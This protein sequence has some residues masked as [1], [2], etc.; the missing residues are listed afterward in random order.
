MATVL[1]VDLPTANWPCDV[2]IRVILSRG[3]RRSP[4]HSVLF[5]LHGLFGNCENWIELTPLVDKM[6]E[7]DFA[8]IAP[9]AW[10]SWYVDSASQPSESYERFF[11]DDL[12]RWADDTFGPF[13]K[14][15]V[16]GLSMGGYGAF[17]FGLKRPDLF[18]FAYSTSGAFVAP[19]IM[20]AT[21]GFD[22]LK[23]SAVT[24]FG[25]DGSPQRRD[26]DIFHLLRSASSGVRTEFV[27][28]CG[29][30]DS[31]FE[32]NRQLADAFAETNLQFSFQ[33]FPGGHD[34]NYWSDRLTNILEAA[35]R[36]L[37]E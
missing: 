11:L 20:E 27:F 6:D 37:S 1:R 33:A 14:R 21:D 35:E 30:E 22:E 8:V 13:R 23:P 25:P 32:I 19:G 3:W 10:E 7:H 31:L 4:R 15:G 17:S 16:A 9:E 29:S 24:A 26:S 5:M 28:D 18:E 36:K 12:L 34:W 2:P